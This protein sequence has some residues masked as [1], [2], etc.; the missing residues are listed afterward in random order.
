M[1]IQTRYSLYVLL[2][3]VMASIGN[4]LTEITLRFYEVTPYI[5]VLLSNFIGGA[6]LMGIVAWQRSP[7]RHGWQKYDWLR[8]VGAAL[9][10]RERLTRWQSE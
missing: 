8:V 4:I 1:T 7:I 9:A 2:T 10:I 5:I 3:A 6:I